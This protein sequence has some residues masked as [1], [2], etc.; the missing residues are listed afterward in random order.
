MC[1]IAGSA[2]I[3]ALLLGCG[4]SDGDERQ[5]PLT[6]EELLDPEACAT[7]HPDHYREWSGSMHAYAA[8]DP[9]FLAMNRRMQRETNGASPS[10]CVQCHAPMA[11]RL[12]ATVDGS[13]LDSVPKKLRGVT[14]V[15][16]HTAIPNGTSGHNNPLMLMEDGVM[17]GG[18]P[19]PVPNAAHASAYSS[20]HDREV[21]EGTAS[22]LCGVCHDI[23]TPAGVEL[24]RTFKEW[25]QSM[26]GLGSDEQTLA[27]SQCHMPSRTDVA[28]QAPG[29]F[30]RQVH[31]HTMAG[32]DL[33]LEAFPEVEAQGQSVQHN[34][35]GAITPKLCV[36]PD[37]GKPTVALVDVTLRN[38]FVG[39]N[40]PS[41]AAQDRRAWVE[42]VAYRGDATVYESGRFA[43]DQ[44]VTGDADPDLFLLRDYIF[45][46]SGA[47]TRMFWQA[48]SY[49]SET[50]PPIVSADPEHP[51][52]DRSVH[53]QYR[54]DGGVGGLVD[55]VTM[56]VH[57][58]PIDVDLVDDLVASGDLADPTLSSKI[59]TFSLAST[60]LEWRAARGFGCVP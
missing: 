37:A 20:A 25:T 2:V 6:D 57:I 30:L 36:Q 10:F 9:I 3:V 45:D 52:F 5:R 38:Q 32:V 23:V 39:H 24:E 29:V 60:R 44:A 13:N 11:V 35:D 21:P 17:R 12:G 58:R 43:P 41:G 42:L 33:A 40:W 8:E 53:H 55:R 1:L 47:E 4:P 50:L 31:D 26:Y 15:F 56:V 48:T 34:L 59:V 7:C 49:K 46:S 51:Q 18:I 16:C 27:C 22:V 54:V 19:N 14:C 28:A